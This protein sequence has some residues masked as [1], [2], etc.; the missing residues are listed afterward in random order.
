[1][2][3]T[4]TEESE[5]VHTCEYHPDVMLDEAG[6]CP[7]CL[8]EIVAFGRW[9]SNPKLETFTEDVKSLLKR[10]GALKQDGTLNTEAGQ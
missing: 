1:M 4:P 2:T 9:R 6:E 8:K 10:T 5:A 7:Q 3:P